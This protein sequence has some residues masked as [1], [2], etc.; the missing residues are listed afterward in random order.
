MR[1]AIAL[2]LTIATLAGCG[3]RDRPSITLY[4]AMKRGDLDQIE[5]HIA[6]GAD[7]NRP[8]SGGQPP[9]HMAAAAGRVVIGRLLIDHGADPNARDR[10]GK[11]ALYRAL[12]RGRTQVAE[13]LVR[14]GARLRPTALLHQLTRAGTADRDVL[15]FLLKRGADIDHL[16]PRGQTP[17][18]QAIVDDNLRLVKHLIRAGA[19]VNRADARGRR[20]LKIATEGGNGAI[21]R[22]LRRNGAEE[23]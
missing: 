9:L 12:E 18:I 23:E 21:I 11:S 13:M 22:L 20:P 7:L 19:D 1:T 10:E 3:Q 14:H 16:D 8:L 5:R 17:L 2:I 15:A 6:W 4:L